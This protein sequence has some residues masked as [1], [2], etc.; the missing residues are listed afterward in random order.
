M[1]S[2][3]GSQSKGGRFNWNS[4]E[5]LFSFK[6]GIWSPCFLPR[7]F[8]PTKGRFTCN[9]NSAI[10]G[11][12]NEQYFNFKILPNHQKGG[13]LLD[14]SSTISVTAFPSLLPAYLWR[15]AEPSC[16]R[17]AISRGILIMGIFFFQSKFLLFG[18]FCLFVIC[19]TNFSLFL[20]QRVLLGKWNCSGT[21]I[22]FLNPPFLL[23]F[24]PYSKWKVVFSGYVWQI[25]GYSQIILHF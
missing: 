11:Q 20:K 5:F 19:P 23:P 2:V 18:V 10:L 9:C 24:S 6:R 14:I 25:S 13:F 21:F 8:F 16:F 12:T 7:D 3:W 17:D 15:L 1:S 22:L 4:S